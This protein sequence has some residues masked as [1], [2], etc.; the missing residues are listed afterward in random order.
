[1]ISACLSYFSLSSPDA[2]AV[3]N[4][5]AVIAAAAAGI[6]RQAFIMQYQN[7]RKRRRKCG[8]PFCLRFWLLRH[9][10]TGVFFYFFF[11]TSVLLNMIGYKMH[12]GIAVSSVFFLFDVT[13]SPNNWHAV[14]PLRVWTKKASRGEVTKKSSQ[15][16]TLYQKM[17]LPDSL[18]ESELSLIHI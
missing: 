8:S 13:G 9:L 16:Q 15:R 6:C 4:H 3:S 10:R 14:C 5:T 11:Q 7:E 17:V 18:R 1:M 2:A 12:L